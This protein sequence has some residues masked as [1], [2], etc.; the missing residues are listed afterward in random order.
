MCESQGNPSTRVTLPACKQGLTRGFQ[1]SDL[2]WKRLASFFWK[3][4]HRGE[5]VETGGS[6]VFLRVDLDC[7]TLA[8]PTT[9]LQELLYTVS[10]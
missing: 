8:N 9:R 2:T 1:Y 10:K 4:G 7:T 5:V 6:P 3:T